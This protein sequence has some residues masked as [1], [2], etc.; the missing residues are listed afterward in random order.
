VTTS[1]PQEE[2][3]RRLLTAHIRAIQ[4]A[5][6]TS[7]G[8]GVI[9]AAAIGIHADHPTASRLFVAVT[10][11]QIAVGL[12]TL[13]RGGRPA[14]VLT[15][16]VNAGAVGAW[17]VTRISG[18]SWIDGL[19]QAEPP[20]FIDTACASLAALAVGSALWALLTDRTRPAAHLGLPALAVAALAFMAM[21][22]GATHVHS[23]SD[24]DNDTANAN[25]L[26]TGAA[27]DH[28]HTDSAT[29][30]TGHP[31]HDDNNTVTT[32]QQTD[33][34]DHAHT[35]SAATTVAYDPT[36][37]IDLSGVD[38]VTPQQQAFAEN[39]VATNVVRLP[40]WSDPAV[41]EAAGFRSIG[42]APLGHEHYVQW[43][44]INDNVWLDPDAPES[45]VYQPQP[46]GTKKLVSAMY[47]LPGTMALSDVPDYGG[48][49]MQWHIHDN[50]CLTA[51]PEAPVVGGLTQPDG[52]CLP[53]LVKPPP[54]PMIHVWI[55]ANPCGP[56]AA[57]EGI[58][59][60][61]IPPGEERW[62]DHT[63]G[64]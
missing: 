56:F 13:V 11:A 57:L 23:H 51:D 6:L 24:A 62:C 64:S 5:G 32:V 37:P 28:H 41:A 35:G 40:Q 29:A 4:I 53:P 52:T 10:A 31:H 46:D 61:Q 1:P 22:H 47:M 16:L 18:I 9:H 44:W 21:L 12:L 34:H 14:A 33:T 50:L 55:T 38:G 8:G 26:N 42:D 39:L 58:A 17:V 27:G 2:Q 45:L 54:S 19:A 3:R 48:R 25:G 59:A 7:I 63:H 20:Q 43:D 49:L 15:A 36:Q 30:T 60:G